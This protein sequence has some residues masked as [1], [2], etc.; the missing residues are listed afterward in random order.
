[1]LLVSDL[2]SVDF[3]SRLFQFFGEMA[4]YDGQPGIYSATGLGAAEAEK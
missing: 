2:F 4:E 1:M 3:F